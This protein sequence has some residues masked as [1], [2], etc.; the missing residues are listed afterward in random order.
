MTFCVHTV[1]GEYPLCQVDAHGSNLSHDF[2][3]GYQIEL[4]QLNLGTSMP[5]P[6][7]GSPFHSL[8]GLWQSELLRN[9]TP[10]IFHQRHLGRV[11][12][13]S[14]NHPGRRLASSRGRELQSGG[15]PP[16]WPGDL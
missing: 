2:P 10:S 5:S 8:G 14:R 16:L 3:S 11:L 15:C 4:R 12:R 9:A 13:S 6:A 7:W 1:N